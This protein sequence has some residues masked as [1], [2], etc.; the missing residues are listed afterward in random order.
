MIGLFI[1]IVGLASYL[2]LKQLGNLSFWTDEI[3]T[4]NFA[5]GNLGSVLNS[6]INRDP[7]MSLF[8][9]LAHFWIH[10]FPNASDGFLR[11]LPALFSIMSIPVVFLLGK[12]LNG[13]AFISNFTGLAA[14]LLVAINAYAIRFAQEFRSYSLLFLLATASTFFLLKMI[15]N[16]VKENRFAVGYVL[17]AVAAIYS[18]FYMV[19]LIA[20]QFLSLLGVWMN[21]KES[22]LSIKRI[23]LIGMGVVIP[24][25]PIFIVAFLKGS[26]QISWIQKFSWDDGYDLFRKITGD[27][28]F[29]LVILTLVFAGIGTY[30]GLLR[31]TGNQNRW[32]IVLVLNCFFAPVLIAILYSLIIK[33]IFVNR[34]LFFVMPYLAVLTATGVAAVVEFGFRRG[35]WHYI[36]SAAGILSLIGLS[37]LSGCGL[38]SYYSS[39]DKEDWRGATKY[40]ARNCSDGFRLYYTT[41]SELNVL[42]YDPNLVSN[43]TKWWKKIIQSGVTDG[44]MEA[45][46]PGN[47]EKVCL[48]LGQAFLQNTQ[49]LDTIKNY[50]HNN[51]S[52]VTDSQFVDIEVLIYEH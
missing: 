10:I 26:G 14:A 24:V 8:T 38:S 21:R 49:T 25:I 15:E 37:F 18:H 40:I 31:Q 41:H 7:N 29:A 39:F 6:I 11:I 20:A 27:Q 12:T 5:K 9:L 47:T 45:L 22:H 30:T 43:N 13:G 19:L 2:R 42:Y 48:I 28:G 16:P 36:A 51:Y 52:K 50:L 33:P 1:G 3:D 34:Y 32:K 23:L 44:K 46:L 17:T 35:R 4:F